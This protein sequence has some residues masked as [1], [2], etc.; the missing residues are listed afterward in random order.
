[1]FACSEETTKLDETPKCTTSPT[2]TTNEVSNLTDTSVTFLGTIGAPT[3]DPTITS[4]GFVYG[5][6]TL[7][8]ITDE[9]IEV[10]GNTISK[11]ITGLQQNQ[12][13]YYRTYFTNPT[14]TYYGNEISF[15][16]NIGV[17][18]LNSNGVTNIKA[19]SADVSSNISSSGGG[20]VIARGVCWSTNPTPTIADSKTE[21]GS[22]LGRF[23]S[24]LVGLTEDTVYNVRTYAINEIGTYYGN[25]VMFSS[26]PDCDVVYLDDNGVTIKA[27][28]CANIGDV[29]VID[30]VQY[31]VVDRGMLDNLIRTGGDLSKI[32]TT[33]L[34]DLSNNIQYRSLFNSSPA[35]PNN[36]NNI[37]NSQ[38]PSIVSWDV[39]NVTD[40]SWMFY[41][42]NSFNQ[43]ISNWDISSVTDTRFMFS[44][45]TSFNGDISAWDFS[46]VTNMKRMFD[47]NNSFNQPIGDWDVSNVTNM[48][49]MFAGDLC[50]TYDNDSDP[51]N[52]WDCSI[53][54]IFNQPIGNWDV[55]NV[56]DMRGMFWRASAFNQD[57]GSW[58]VSN[59]TD[60]SVMF[61]GTLAAN[62]NLPNVFNQPIDNWNVSNVTDMRGMFEGNNSFNQPLGD[63]DVGNLTSC[64]DFDYNTPSWTLPKPNFTNCN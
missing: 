27:Y 61:A 50:T 47:S 23:T 17:V 9:V 32:C 55:S 63:W 20:N 3:C 58:D 34:T 62:V 12:T 4:Q 41:L 15:Q 30:G 10:N 59:V 57:I 38:T 52:D 49:F 14:G 48:S 18:L 45:A 64:G 43:D 33:Y 54:P 24:N 37:Y 39:S 44:N 7:P 60:M 16:T 36:F 25:V 40:M 35:Y 53:L 19:F 42:E 22:G 1:M 11:E 28:P 21:D 29:G 56:T 2:L 26:L 51:F 6:S 13:Y 46:N 5:L 8:K 31:T